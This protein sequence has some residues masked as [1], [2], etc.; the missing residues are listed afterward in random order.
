VVLSTVILASFR[1]ALT[2]VNV[3]GQVQNIVTGALL[4][5]SVVVP[6]APEAIRRLRQRM[7]SR[8]DAP[9]SVAAPRPAGPTTQPSPAPP[10]ITA[11]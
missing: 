10:S 6:N 5:V 8:P 11:R 7:R 9:P 4:L 3:S 1:D 2:L